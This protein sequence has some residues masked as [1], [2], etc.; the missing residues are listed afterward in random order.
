MAMKIKIGDIEFTCNGLEELGK[1]LP[2]KLE[3]VN[4]EISDCNERLKKLKKQSKLL[5]KT[6]KDQTKA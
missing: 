4:K 5:S 2:S 6:I 3:A 1:M